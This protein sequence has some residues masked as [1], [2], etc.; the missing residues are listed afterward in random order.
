MF[1][2]FG[3]LSYNLILAHQ[4]M[5]PGSDVHDMS[6]YQKC[7]IGGILSCGLTHTMVCPLDIV[8]CRMQVSNY[9]LVFSFNNSFRVFNRQC[10]VCTKVLVT[11]LNKFVLLRE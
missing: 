6:Y 7:M 4:K 2:N 8:K 1:F 11:D 9:T 10:Q 5:A 3:L